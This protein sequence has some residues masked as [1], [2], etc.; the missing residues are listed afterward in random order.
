MHDDITLAAAGTGAQVLG[1]LG[2]GGI[3]LALATTL[4]LGTRDK[5]EHG[6]NKG[7]AVTCG[8][9]AGTTFT[10]AGHIWEMPNDLTLGALHALKIGEGSGPLGDVQPGAVALVLVLIAYLVRL[11][12]R[13]AGVN[14]LAMATV[15]ANA[16]GG[17]A[18][19][20]AG[21]GDFFTGLAS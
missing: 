8:L 4:V 14:G 1:T 17:W 2:T 13:A 7:Q 18:I 20:A 6:L 16:G 15:F 10:A 19:V 21:I 3:A 11:K 9:A 5:S 12:P